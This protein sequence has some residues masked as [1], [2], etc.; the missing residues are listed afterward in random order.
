MHVLLATDGSAPS[1]DAAA[2]LRAEA[3]PAGSTLE[4]L[5]VIERYRTLTDG[6]EDAVELTEA[7]AREAE[8]NVTRCAATF[9]RPGLAVSTKVRI[10]R[11]T[12]EITAEAELFG[13]D[14]VVL[15]SRGRGALASTLLGSVAAGVID[16]APCP[17][18]AVRGSKVDR[19]L[20]G[21]DG[22]TLAAAAVDFLTSS[23]FFPRAHLD[24]LGVVEFGP[25][26]AVG[27]EWYGQ[28]VD[29]LQKDLKGCV[30]RSAARLRDA[31]YDARSEVI[32]GTPAPALAAEA[33]GR[34]TSLMVLGSHGRTGMARVLLGSVARG[35]LTHVPC[36]VLIVRARRA[37][38]VEAS[39]SR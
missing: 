36:S 23:H 31:G 22:S 11:A 12:E 14:L 13:A 39:A 9:E 33:K 7:A 1:D 24:V 6:G 32:V 2:V 34:A 8:G 3:L 25:P 30:E 10:G 4:V 26:L 29:A 19:I 37:A 17:V 35:V 20:I 21:D 15:G 27:G 38:P 18:L 5:T 16:R 28:T